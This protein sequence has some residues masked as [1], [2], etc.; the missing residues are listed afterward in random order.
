MKEKKTTGEAL[1]LIDAQNDYFPGGKFSLKGMTKATRNA[2]KLLAEFRAKGLPV[3]HVRH[4]NAREGA[5]FFIPGTTGAEIHPLVAP[6]E[7]ERVFVKHYPSSFRETGLH[8]Y[9]TGLG[10]GTLHLAG[11]QTNMCVDTT[12]RAGF[13][14]GYAIVVHGDCCAAPAFLGTNL[15]HRLFLKNLAVFARVERG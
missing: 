4:E 2:A 3:I 10:I 12:T 13:D 14:L 7:G 9:L 5:K 15:I 6:I 8:D 1:I 11:A